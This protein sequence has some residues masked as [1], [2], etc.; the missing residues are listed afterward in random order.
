[1]EC[2]PLLPHEQ[3]KLY[4]FKHGS[5]FE[6]LR[7][8]KKSVRLVPLEEFEMS[9]ISR[10]KETIDRKQCMN[11]YIHN[12]YYIYIRRGGIDIQ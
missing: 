3:K 11:K 9:K 4:H 5:L 10:Q 12:A 1:M 2:K 8:N 7:A 6:Y